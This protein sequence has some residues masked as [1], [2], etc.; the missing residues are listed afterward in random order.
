MPCHDDRTPAWDRSGAPH[1]IEVPTRLEADIKE[2]NLLTRVA[3]DMR[4]ILRRA[5]LEEHLTVETRKWI[6]VHDDWD[7][8]RTAEERASGERQRVAQQGLDKLTLD[9][10]RALGL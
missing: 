2:I 6:K 9:E 7:R 10:R 1:T 5:G 3:C 4:T 8:R